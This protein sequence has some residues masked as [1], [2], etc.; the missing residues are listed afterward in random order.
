MTGINYKGLGTTE[1]IR[2]RRYQVLTYSLK[3]GKPSEVAAL[4]GVKIKT[5]YDDIAYLHSHRLQ[6]APIEVYRDLGNSWYEMKITELERSSKE[7]K[8]SP[9]WVNLQN[10]I[11]K[12]KTDQLKLIGAFVEHIEHSGS[13]VQIVDNIPQS[14]KID[15]LE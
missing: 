11:L 7:Y 4:I 1:K 10:T 3:G 13:V 15:P 2:E 12:Y 8:G 9:V 14:K 5:V 6:D